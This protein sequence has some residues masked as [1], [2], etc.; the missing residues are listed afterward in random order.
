MNLYILYPMPISKFLYFSYNSAQ[1]STKH[2][3]TILCSQLCSS[4]MKTI[5]KCSKCLY[6]ISLYVVTCSAHPFHLQ[7]CCLSANSCS[8]P[9]VF[10]IHFTLLILSAS[11]MISF[12]CDTC[13][14]LKYKWIAFIIYYWMHFIR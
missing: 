8:V 1:T 13:L 9:E 10:L 3:Y 12:F 14:A 11:C 7:Y 5:N 4:L 2:N 6:E